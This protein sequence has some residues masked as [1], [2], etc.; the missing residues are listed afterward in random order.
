MYII[1]ASNITELL[2]SCYDKEHNVSIL[3]TY[4]IYCVLFFTNIGGAQR[5]ALK[6]FFTQFLLTLIIA[7]NYT[8]NKINITLCNSNAKLNDLLY[9]KLIRK[10]LILK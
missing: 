5:K 6:F 1:A 8:M 9:F 10:Y 7:A 4:Y 3:V 2:V